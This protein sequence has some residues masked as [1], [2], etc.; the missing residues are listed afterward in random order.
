MR[1]VT[2]IIIDLVNLPIINE[3]NKQLVEE[4]RIGLIELHSRR[5]AMSYWG[6][7]V[8]CKRCGQISQKGYV[9]INCNFDGSENE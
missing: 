5:R 4:I 6:Q 7:W 9:C 3:K 1:A 8:Q 2:D